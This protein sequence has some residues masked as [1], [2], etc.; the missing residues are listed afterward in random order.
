MNPEPELLQALLKLAIAL[1][2]GLLVGMQRERTES[3]IAGIRTFPLA[4]V[5]GTITGF[6]ALWF[7][8][9]IVA[10]G[11]LS[12]TGLVIMGNLGSSRELSDPGLTTEVALL[13]MFGI[14]AYLVSGH[15]AVAVALGGTV[16]V[17]LHLK[18]EMHRFVRRMGNKDFKS[19]MQ[20]V[21]ITV[22]ILP[23]LPNKGYGPYQALNPFKI[24]LLVVF[25]VAMRLAGYV[26]YKFLG[27]RGGSFVSALLGGLISSTATTVSHARQA[28]QAAQQ[29]STAAQVI[30]AA[31]A[32]VFIRLLIII[33]IVAPSLFLGLS[34]PLS[35]MLGATAL[36]TIGL[37]MV[38]HK[39]SVP[40]AE[41]ENPSELKPALVFAFI[42]A[43]VQLGVAAGKQYFGA[44]G[45][46]V[47]AF[48]SGLP[49]VDAIALSTLQLAQGNQLGLDMAWRMIVVGTL[50]NFLFKAAI[51]A[52]LGNRRLLAKIAVPFGLT[53]AAGTLLLWLWP[54]ASQVAARI[55]P[56]VEPSIL[57][58]GLHPPFPPAV[59][60]AQHPGIPESKTAP[61]SSV[62]LDI[63]LDSNK[64]SRSP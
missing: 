56:A 50:A 61:H 11:F 64:H 25:I 4:T 51:V 57:P 7:S 24:W 26:A 41:Q 17:L 19:V 14:G 27:T 16:A 53:L 36:I 44:S 15:T 30:M 1:G 60:T 29:T 39:D 35:V 59:R 37:W 12:L 31:S 23:V 42:F 43:L 63:Q 21:L 52:V 5:L 54:S 9:W 34:A 8:G 18:P 6:L 49:D 22:V 48:L 32:V 13:L 58:G 20:F 40:A 46:Y 2:L 55:P 10:A 45:L 28:R 47:V 38:Q 33:A 62:K 3:R